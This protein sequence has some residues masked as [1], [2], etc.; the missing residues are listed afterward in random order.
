M[1]GDL[2]SLMGGCQGARRTELG[3]FALKGGGGKRDRGEGMELDH[4]SSHEVWCF[5]GSHFLIS[6]IQN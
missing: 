5:G 2:V 6:A 4:E 1:A 3:D